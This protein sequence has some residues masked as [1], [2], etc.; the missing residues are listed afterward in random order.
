MAQLTKEQLQQILTKGLKLVAPDF[1]LEKTDGRLSG[2]VISTSFK[3]KRDHERQEMIWEALHKAL[4]ADSV[5]KVGLLLP[6][7][8][9][10]WEMGK[11]D[12]PA[13]GKKKAG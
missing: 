11:S 8:P 6:Y 4:G 13:P 5:Q 9:D 10:E 12:E 2:N 7:T 1:M 3:G